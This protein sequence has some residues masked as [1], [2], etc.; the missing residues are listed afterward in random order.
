MVAFNTA[1]FARNEVISLGDGT[2]IHVEVPPCG[3]AVTDA[4]EHR[5]VASFAHPVEIIERNRLIALDNGMLRVILDRA[6]GNI[7]SIHDHRYD[8]EV[9]APGRRG[10]CIPTPPGPA[11]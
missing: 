5:P 1:G 11:E 2:P 4:A 3:Y 8:R 10:K 6:T 7:R 9:L